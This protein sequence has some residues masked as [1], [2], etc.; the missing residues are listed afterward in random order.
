M[1]GVS[2]YLKTWERWK[3]ATSPPVSRITPIS[4]LMYSIT[5]PPT[6]TY[7]IISN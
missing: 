3:R 7:T 2:N 6:T 5:S 1:I 4:M